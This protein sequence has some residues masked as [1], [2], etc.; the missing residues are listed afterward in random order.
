M[1]TI[2]FRCERCNVEEDVPEEIVKMLDEMDDG[3]D[4]V[5]PRFKCEK[6]PGLM[7]PIKYKNYTWDN[8]AR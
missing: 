2:K 7:Y 4:L 3:D 8:R 6:C 1:K 5:A